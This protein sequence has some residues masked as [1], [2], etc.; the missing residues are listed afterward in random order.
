MSAFALAYELVFLFLGALLFWRIH[1]LP[2]VT[3]SLRDPPRVSAVNP[4]LDEELVIPE[5]LDSLGIQTHQPAE[6]VVVDDGSTDATARIAAFH[7]A[8][9]I[10]TPPRPEGWVG[11]SWA[12]WIGA[13]AAECEVLLFLDA[14]V[15]LPP[16]ALERLCAA[17]A[18]EGGM[19]TVQSYQTPCRAYERLSAIFSIVVM[20]GLDCFT[21][22]GRRI[23]PSRSFG[24]CL[25]MSRE[26]YFAADGH[27]SVHTDVI[28]DVALGRRWRD[29]G[30]HVS[31]YGGKGSVNF[32]MY[33]GGLHQ[34]VEG[35]TRSM[36]SGASG[37]RTLT[38]LLAILWICGCTGAT[39]HLGIGLAR[40]FLTGTWAYAGLAVCGYALYALEIAWMLRR[41]GGFGG[42]TAVLFFVPLVFFHFVFLRSLLFTHIL[43]PVRWRGR[44]I[45]T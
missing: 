43:R 42:A 35:W 19:V 27:R 10:R 14:D 39:T 24:P 37:I 9:V 4:A 3:E 11:K 17:H 44:T 20:M 34:L 22:L 12:C 32:R 25:L 18:C 16:S 26:D 28:E 40:G 8:R 29:L 6:I 2:G 5:L 21:A 23:R 1:R 31:W 36:A 41:T 13:G 30:R 45:R 38:L 7:G 33:P 15:V